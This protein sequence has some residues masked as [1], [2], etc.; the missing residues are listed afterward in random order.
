MSLYSSAVKKPI[1]TALIFLALAIFGIFS[2]TQLS[3][4]LYPHIE[5]N[6]IMVMTS[7]PG[8]SASDIE[9]NVTKPIENRLNSVSYLKHITSSSKENMSIVSLEFQ[10]GRDIDAAT[11]DVRDKLEMVK[12]N[13]PDGA[14][15]PIIFKFGSDDIPILILSVTAKESTPGLYKLLDDGIVNEL[16]RVS[17]VGSVSMSG[18]SQREVKVYCDPYKL[19]AYNLTLEAVSQAI[20]AENRNTPG[21]SIE[22][23][24]N[25]YTLRVQKEFK[26]PSEME[27]LVVGSFNGKNVYLKDVAR[28]ADGL[29]ERMQEAYIN[30]GKGGMIIIQK[31]TGENSVEISNRIM[32]KLPDLQRSLPSDV[33]LGIIVNTSDNIVNTIGSLKETIFTTLLLVML[34]V[35]IFLGRWRATFIIVLTIPISLLSSLTYLLATGNTLNII[36]M[37]SLAIAIGMVVDDAIVV[38]ENVITHLDRGSAPKQAAVY[39]TN[40]VALSVVATT[41]TML[42]VF[43]PLTMISGMAG[44]LFRQLGWLVSIVSIV[45]T[46]CALALTP[47]MCSKMLRTHNTAKESTFYKIVFIPINKGL[48]ALNRGYAKLLDWAVHH[49]NSVYLIALGSFAAVILLLAPHMKTEFFPTQDNARISATLQLPVGTRQ[50]ITRDLAME[51]SEKFKKD[52]PEIEVISFSEGVA[53]TDNLFASMQN[54]GSHM[55]SF[56]IRLCSMEKRKRTLTEIS[57][58]MM[59]QLS[60]YP[61]LRKYNVIAGGQQGS[62]GGQQGTQIE[63]YGY[64]FA[65]TDKMAR[66]VVK[67]FK[68]IPGVSQVVVSRDEYVPEFQVD[69]DREKVALNGLTT[70]GVASFL[71]NRMNGAISSEYRDEGYEY[72]IRVRYAPEYRQSIS[73]VENIT[74][75]NNAGKPVKLRELGKVKE[76]L[77]PPTIER[78]DRERYI[79]VTAALPAGMAASDLNS[80]ITAKINNNIDVPAG[81]DWKIGGSFDD[82]TSMYSD[83]ITLMVLIVILVFIV[84]A[85]EFES[86]TYPFVIMFSI[87]FAFVGV[88]IGLIVTQTNMSVMAMIGVI[89]LIGIVVKNGIV[90]VDY[91]NLCRE[92]GLSVSKSVT[93]AGHSRL[94]PVLMTTLTTVLGM[95]PL[96]IGTGEGSEMW[97][98]MGMT[99]AWGLSIS[100]LVTLVIIPTMYASFASFGV[101]RKRKAA[102]KQQ[103]KAA[104][105]AVK[106]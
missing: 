26:D 84:M 25:T 45:S 65:S 61:Q 74:I 42:A 28:L 30:G 82:Q 96:A 72:D 91:T 101:R 69:L 2:Y 80:A 55:I 6:A 44:I 62:V 36:S 10:Y 70:T 50:E 15:T 38:L 23:G 90:L 39:A 64:D 24:S 95:V 54:S 48:E 27:N 4:D 37:S 106:K 8:A 41:L 97:K 104:L 3:V 43:L 71:R 12:T 46:V 56:N 81:I 57:D 66:D 79:S 52:Y 17:G 78:K 58:D 93:T 22:L 32:A 63:I 94:R 29:Q 68:S 102:I 35:Y 40:E 31:Q 105:A 60:K 99:V 5:S 47:M 51:I 89:M 77:T 19:D 16:A 7:Y 85:A 87:P 98:G 75:Y 103:R 83:L 34:V 21:G 67:E 13:L 1:A 59:R 88:L 92:R 11:N 49:R 33:K 86:L 18:I 9:S 53:D 100:T 76:A 20:A 73:D 14:G